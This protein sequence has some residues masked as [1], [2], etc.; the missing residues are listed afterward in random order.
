M[1]ICALILNSSAVFFE[2]SCLVMF[3][4]LFI[5]G[6]FDVCLYILSWKMLTDHFIFV[7]FDASID[8]LTWS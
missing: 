8:I 2:F 6:T 1:F 5:L 3:F 7:S 4:N